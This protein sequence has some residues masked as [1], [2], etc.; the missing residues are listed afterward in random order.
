[1]KVL[2]GTRRQT[3]DIEWYIVRYIAIDS[4]AFSGEMWF[5][6]AGPVVSIAMILAGLPDWKNCKCFFKK[7]NCHEWVQCFDIYRGL[8]SCLHLA[9]GRHHRRR[10]LR[11]PHGLQFSRVKV[12][13]A[14]HTHTCSGIYHKLS[15]L[16]FDGGCGPKNPLIGGRIECSFLLFFELVNIPDKIPCFPGCASSCLCD[17]PSF[18]FEC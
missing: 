12:S 2:K 9:V 10:I 5:L 17:G 7:H 4:F 11:Y 1:M 8:F 14:D 16:Q 3:K 6:T 15:F 13:L 18:L